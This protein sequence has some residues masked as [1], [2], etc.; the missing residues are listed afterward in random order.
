VFSALI[1]GQTGKAMTA[2]LKEFSAEDIALFD[3]DSDK[4]GDEGIAKAFEFNQIII[5]DDGG[6]GVTAEEAYSFVSAYQSRYSTVWQTT[7]VNNEICVTS[8]NPQGEI[9]WVNTIPKKQIM[10]ETQLFSSY[11]MMVSGSKMYFL[12]NDHEDNLKNTLDTKAK[13]ISTFKDAVAT[14]VTINADGK[15]TRDQAFDVNDDTGR[16]LI[17]AKQCRQIGSDEMFF[18]TTRYQ[19]LGKPRL[20]MGT[21]KEVL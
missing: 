7:Y 13:R 15:M 3:T 4:S 19:L 8:I 5:R 12:Y 9:E 10:S 18:I 21:L 14:V 20:I 17:V 1:N 6:I 16:G 11:T 2:N